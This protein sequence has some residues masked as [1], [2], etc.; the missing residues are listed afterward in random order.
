[1]VFY[2]SNMLF[3]LRIP[4]TVVYQNHKNQTKAKEKIRKG[5]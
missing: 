4:N 5:L 3:S 1:M 2:F